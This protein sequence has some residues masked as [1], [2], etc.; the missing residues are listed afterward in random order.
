MSAKAFVDTNILVYSRDLSEPVKG[1]VART[2]VRSLWQNRNGR[3][4][5]QVCSEYFV[6]VTKK[7]SA[8]MNEQEA[9][10]DVEDLMAWN[11]VPISQEC[12]KIGRQ[13]QLRYRLSWWDSLIVAAASISG[14]EKIYTEDLNHRQEYLGMQIINPFI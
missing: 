1:E 14:C 7:L 9:W 3:I 2:L 13:V 8:P 4:S 10:D 6:T 11:P 5:T 12:L